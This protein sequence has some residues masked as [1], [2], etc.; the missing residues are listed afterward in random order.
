[1]FDTL[2]IGQR[3]KERSMKINEQVFSAIAAMLDRE[4]PAPMDNLYGVWHWRVGSSMDRDGSFL[5]IL[6]TETA[7]DNGMPLFDLAWVDETT[8]YEETFDAAG[9]MNG[10]SYIRKEADIAEILQLCEDE[11][12]TPTL[13]LEPELPA[14]KPKHD[15]S[16]PRAST[17]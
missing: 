10:W 2:G 3:P 4:Y 11:A 12:Y 8:E 14:D 16:G 13:P 6:D 7:D 9:N 15:A 5:V 1:M 17:R